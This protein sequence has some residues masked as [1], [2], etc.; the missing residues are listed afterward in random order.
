MQ[1]RSNGIFQLAAAALALTSGSAQ[2]GTLS[3]AWISSAG[4][5]NGSCG[6]IT[7]PCRHL[8]QALLNVAANAEI[9]VKDPGAYGPGPI[10][11]T[12]GVS[13]INNGVGTAG[14]QAPS[15]Q[16]AIIITAPSTDAV[17]IVGLNIGG[18]GGGVNGIQFNSGLGV[19]LVDTTISGFAQN[20]I[21]YTPNNGAGKFSFLDIE[22]GSLANN[23]V[24]QLNAVP[25]GG[26]SASITMRNCDVSLNASTTGALINLDNSTNG[27]SNSSLKATITNCSLHHA[28]N[29]G[30]NIVGPATA[31][32]VGVMFD[33][34]SIASVNTPIVANG[35]NAALDLNASTITDGNAV[36][37]A[38]NGAVVSSFGNNAIDFGNSSGAIPLKALQ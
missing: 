27:A 30:I 38:T 5:D 3:K 14:I 31:S 12:Q 22:G 25:T 21:N 33:H 35:A 24:N 32:Q 37:T 23:T 4:V 13:I 15:G 8:S 1:S 19:R 18:L 29:V 17:V 36:F 26:S 28:A 2:A 6:A 11:I 7:A 34:S 10:T 16:D 9:D 20:G